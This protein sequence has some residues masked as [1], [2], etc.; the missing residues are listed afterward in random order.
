[1]GLTGIVFCNSING[2]NSLHSYLAESRRFGEYAPL[3]RSY[4]ASMPKHVKQGIIEQL[5]NGHLKVLIATN[6]LG[7]E[8]SLKF[9]H[10]CRSWDRSTLPRLRFAERWARSIINKTKDI[11]EVE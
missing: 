6:A 1:M 2:V 4:Y 11:P 10:Q 3:I 9:S 5:K 7:I 8:I